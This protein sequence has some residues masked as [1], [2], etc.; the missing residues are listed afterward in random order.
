[1]SLGNSSFFYQNDKSPYLE[2]FSGSWDEI[3][4]LE[5]LG[6][7]CVASAGND[8]AGRSEDFFVVFGSGESDFRKIDANTSS[9]QVSELQQLFQMLF[10]LGPLGLA[11]NK[12]CHQEMLKTKIFNILFTA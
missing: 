8:Y 1:M 5:E 4:A 2:K 9:V 11:M 6:V 10:P 7:I 12:A 3:N